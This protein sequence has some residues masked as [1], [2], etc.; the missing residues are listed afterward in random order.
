MESSHNYYI[1]Q[2]ICDGDLEKYIDNHKNISEEHATDILKQICNGFMAL[3]KEGIVHRDLKPANIMLS[4]GVVKIGD[5]GFAKK[6]ITKRIKN[7][8]SVGTPLYM[9]IQILKSEPYTSKCDIWAVG[10]IF[11]E[12]LHNKTPWTAQTE[13]ELVKNIETKPAKINE[14]LHLETQDFLKKCLMID[15]DQR[16][17]W[18]H[19]FM[20]PIFKG[21]F[22]QYALQNQQFEDKLKMVMTELRFQ[23]NSKNIDLNKLLES[24]GMKNEKELNFS[25]FSDFLRYIH[26]NITKDEIKFFFEKMDTNEDGSISIHEL[27][28]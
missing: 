17:G 11:Y 18:D 21:Y 1:I 13:F 16:I 7:A 10:F 19:V 14:S 26:P 9:P 15:E 28:S 22:K 24:M 3:V 2:E 4:K 6:N 8:T 23:I 20:H 12:L 5:F 27:S 25:Q